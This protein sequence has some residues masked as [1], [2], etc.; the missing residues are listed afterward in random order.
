MENNL[1]TLYATY[2]KQPITSYQFMK[3]G[4]FNLIETYVTNRVNYLNNIDLVESPSLE[5][6]DYEYHYLTDI[7]KIAYIKKHHK[8]SGLSVGK[9]KDSSDNVKIFYVKTV[10]LLGEEDIKNSSNRVLHTYIDAIEKSGS[11][12]NL[13][14]ILKT[15]NNPENII[16]YI[17]NKQYKG[18]ES[19][20]LDRLTTILG[21]TKRPDKLIP[22]LNKLLIQ[23]NWKSDVMNKGCVGWL[24]SQGIVEILH[25]SSSPKKIYNLLTSEQKEKWYNRYS[26]RRNVITILWGG[27]NGAELFNIFGEDAVKAFEV[28][29]KE[30]NLINS[31]KE[32]FG[33]I[34][35]IFKCSEKYNVKISEKYLKPI[36]KAILNSKLSFKIL[37]HLKQNDLWHYFEQF[38]D[39]DSDMGADMGN[40][41][42]E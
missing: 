7:Q 33:A 30:D 19:T 40:L 26:H 5:L 9:Y 15:V 39:T 27:K 38:A 12:G 35:N 6:K 29:L 22:I 37:N 41:G 3:L 24:E 20:I 1:L 18:F 25:K 17:Y 13:G 10:R 14:L 42:F 23:S 21:T 2:C 16:Y 4:N 34:N 28:M 31:E 11:K 32:L 8:N 36:F